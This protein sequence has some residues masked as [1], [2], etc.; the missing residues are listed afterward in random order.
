MYMLIIKGKKAIYEFKEKQFNQILFQLRFALMTE[1]GIK[2]ESF[3][4]EELEF[5]K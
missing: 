5:F 4:N 2:S 1:I 3:E